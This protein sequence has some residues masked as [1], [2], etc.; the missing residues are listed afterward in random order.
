MGP[1][2]YLTL[3]LI[4]S[5][6]TT[7]FPAFAYKSEKSL[8]KIDGL[9]IRLIPNNPEPVE[10]LGVKT[11]SVESEGKVLRVK[12]FSQIRNE[13]KDGPW[14]EYRIS[15]KQGTIQTHGWEE[16]ESLCLPHLWY[17]GF[18]NLSSTGLLW[19]PPKIIRGSS[20][21]KKTYS[22]EPC[23][24]D[25]DFLYFRKGPEQLIERI[26]EFRKAVAEGEGLQSFLDD[27]S[28]VKVLSRRKIEPL[29]INANKTEVSTVVVGNKYVEYT[30]LKSS[31]NPLV[32]SLK[33]KPSRAPEAMKPY[34]DFFHDYLEYRITQIQT[35]Q[36][37]LNP[38]L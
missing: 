36:S 12:W 1:R 24:L 27:F 30:V 18:L 25:D 33:F 32:L 38:P 6:T 22:L 31:E 16:A 9:K 21:T 10:D 3:L 26:E 14:P 2:S 4:L 28:R 11:I 37:S 20:D 23:I 29:V 35:P 15:M 17:K 7:V 5:A 13:I 19:I 34:L 8:P